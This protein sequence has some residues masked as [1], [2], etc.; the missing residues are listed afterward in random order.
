MECTICNLKYVCKNEVP[1]SIRLNNHR[2]DVK[3]KAILADKYFPKRDH[4][5]NEHARFTI[6]DRLTNTNLNK[7]ILRERLTQRENFWIKL[8]TLY[9][10]GLNQGL[11]MQI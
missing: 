1:F 3:A 6:T 9:P 11:N 2:K 5:L 7:E 8:E 4:R 10:K